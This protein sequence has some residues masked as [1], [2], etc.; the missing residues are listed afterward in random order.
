MLNPD[1]V[2]RIIRLNRY[3]HHFKSLAITKGGGQTP[4]DNETL[5]FSICWAVNLITLRA[6]LLSSG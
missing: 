3:Y 2:T 1:S 5:D 6:N 4:Q